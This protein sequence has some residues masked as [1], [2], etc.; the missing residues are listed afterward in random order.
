MREEEIRMEAAGVTE[1]VEEDFSEP[2]KE[3][4]EIGPRRGATSGRD[5]FFFSKNYL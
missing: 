3:E 5:E 1:D 2:E 4:Q